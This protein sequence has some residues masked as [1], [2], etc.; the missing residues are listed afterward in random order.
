MSWLH[1]LPS[2]STP[3]AHCGTS[4]RYRAP[5][6]EKSTTDRTKHHRQNRTQSQ[7]HAQNH[8]RRTGH[9]RQNRIR[10]N[11]TQ[12]HRQNK[13]IHI[14]TKHH[15]QNRIRQK[16]TQSM[17]RTEP[18]TQTETK[19]PSR[20]GADHG[21]KKGH[22]QMTCHLAQRGD[23]QNTMSS[24]IQHRRRNLTKETGHSK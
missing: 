13:T 6:T 14:E 19:S 5:Q 12:S 20:G 10:Q 8:S 24:T 23:V 15:R 2:S 7:C 1:R 21:T 18:F 4:E 9:H 16:W 3:I 11:R 17:H 22:A